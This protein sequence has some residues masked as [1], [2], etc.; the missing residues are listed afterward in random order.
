MLWRQG[1]RIQETALEEDIILTVD[2]HDETRVVR[3][4]DAVTQAHQEVQKRRAC[5]LVLFAFPALDRRP[6]RFL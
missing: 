5:P 2:Y 6:T 1:C 4:R 3:R